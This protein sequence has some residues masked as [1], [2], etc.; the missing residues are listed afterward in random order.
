MKAKILIVE[1]DPMLALDLRYEVELL[2]YEVVGLVESADEALVASEENRPDLALMD[3]N[4][5]GSMDGIQTARMLHAA[6]RIPVIFLTSASDGA[7]VARAS[8][9]ELYGYLIKPV[10]RDELK[11]SIHVALYKA[12]AGAARESAHNARPAT[13]GAVPQGVLSVTLD[14]KIQFMNAAAEQMVGCALL[15]A[16]GKKIH[17]VLNLVDSRERALPEL[18]NASDARAIEEFGCLLT[19][20]R[21]QQIVVDFS[22]TPLSD[23]SGYRTGFVITLRNAAERLRSQAV[24][25]ILD[26]VHCFDMAPTPMIQLDGNGYI[27]R[28]NAAMLRESGVESSVIVGRSLTGLSMDPDP[29]IAQDLFNKLLQAGTSFV[30]THAGNVH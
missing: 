9:E 14:H 20:R 15:E 6:D 30:T 10:K 25:E 27:V 13:V 16:R 21:G 8:R 24:E 28:I 12:A 18:N 29:R 3:I 26:E 1:D 17:D 5:A 2:G 19:S 22:A 11:A 7:T 4:I 23:Q